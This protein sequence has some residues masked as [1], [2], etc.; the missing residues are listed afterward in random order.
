MTKSI[1]KEA[2]LEELVF[3]VMER[4]PKLA[5]EVPAIAEKL[6]L[7][8][9]ENNISPSRLIAA[10]YTILSALMEKKI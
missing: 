6:L 3:A 2:T 1:L 7:F 9:E 10:S 8:M 4:D 5:A